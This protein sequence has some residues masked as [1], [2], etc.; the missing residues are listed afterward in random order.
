MLLLFFIIILPCIVHYTVSSPCIIVLSLCSIEHKIQNID[1]F[2]GNSWQQ[3]CSYI[4]CYLTIARFQ[5]QSNVVYNLL[6]EGHGLAWEI[7]CVEWNDFCL[8]VYNQVGQKVWM[9]LLQRCSWLNLIN[10]SRKDSHWKWFICAGAR[11]SPAADS[12]A[13]SLSAYLRSS[14]SLTLQPSLF[15]NSIIPIEGHNKDSSNIRAYTIGF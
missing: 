13:W 8:N 7:I 11:P 15:K 4:Y 14:L 1:I 6:H 9:L 2:A 12:E 10:F 5:F 3:Y